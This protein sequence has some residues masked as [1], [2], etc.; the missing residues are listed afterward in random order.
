[1]II[2]RLFSYS[3]KY[4][5]KTNNFFTYSHT[6]ELSISGTLSSHVHITPHFFVIK[7][8]NGL[9][10]PLNFKFAKS[11]KFPDIQTFKHLNYSYKTHKADN[12]LK[13]IEKPEFDE[14]QKTLE[15]KGY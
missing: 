10:F 3:N 1:M 12:L 11:S 8:Y 13:E 9:S 15:I 5:L 2:Q 7:K 14:N 6:V 4:N